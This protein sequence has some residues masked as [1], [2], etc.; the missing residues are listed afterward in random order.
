[1]LE[2]PNFINLIITDWQNIFQITSTF[3]KA[4]PHLHKMTLNLLKQYLSKQKLNIIS[5]GQY[6]RF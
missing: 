2:N 3:E 6:L 5:Y 4:L 1:M